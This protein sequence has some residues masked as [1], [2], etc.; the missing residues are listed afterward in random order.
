MTHD[1]EKGKHVEEVEDIQGNKKNVTV[2]SAKDR[3]IT[4]GVTR[5]GGRPE[6]PVK[7]MDKG[8]GKDA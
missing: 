2:L 7:I 1:T 5:V 8:S 3:E 6:T 4:R